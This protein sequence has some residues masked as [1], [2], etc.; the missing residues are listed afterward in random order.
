MMWLVV[1]I[2]GRPA[3]FLKR[4]GGGVDGVG[5][6]KEGRERDW[7]GGGNCGRDVNE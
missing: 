3:F 6:Q 7:G 1:D 4:N 2:Y 5:G